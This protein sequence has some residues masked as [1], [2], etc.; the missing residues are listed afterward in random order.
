[1]SQELSS[2]RLTNKDAIKAD[3]EAIGVRLAVLQRQLLEH[4]IPVLVILDGWEAAGKGTIIN[5][6]LSWLDPRGYEVHSIGEPSR[7]EKRRPYLW[8]WWIKTPATGRIVILEHA[9]Y[10]QWKDKSLHDDIEG[11]E[12]MLV[13]SG[14]IL[15]KIFLKVSQAEQ[16]KRLDDLAAHKSTA[17]RVGKREL[18]QN[19]QYGKEAKAFAERLQTSAWPHA[20]W[21]IIDADNS[22]AAAR[23]FFESLEKAWQDGVAKAVQTQKLPG[24]SK[25]KPRHP[26][27][28]SA[29]D[30]SCTLDREQ[31][32][33]RLGKAQEKIR[34]LQFDLY[35][36]QRSAVIVFEGQDAAGKGGAI[37]RLCHSMDPR[38]YNVV[39]VAAPGEEEKR[40]HYLWRF[41]KNLPK[42]GHLT[43]FDRSWYGRVL[44][45]R[46]E[47]FCSVVEWERSYDEIR[48]FEHHLHEHGCTVLKFWLQTD[49]DEQL[50]RF[51][52]RQSDPLKQWKITAEDWR[53]REKRPAYTVAVNEMLD[54]TH[55]AWAPWILVPANDKLYARVVV[56]EALI[57]ALCMS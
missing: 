26:D 17:W 22:L 40:H 52:D 56:L 2:A 7:E 49:A 57:D 1:M 20:P 5:R 48:T 54:R 18:T 16:K 51:E 28:V 25:A 23:Q 30:L 41:W 6:L 44:V 8:R 45:E 36:K 38:G 10:Q 27:Y 37:K 14:V 31:Y 55:A 39:P 15:S 4:K 11:L 33:L 29:M 46:V 12:S 53:N 3:I 34:A 19:K 13:A 47:G 42:D 35:R 50:K 43:I 9:W 24:K 21:I 32:E